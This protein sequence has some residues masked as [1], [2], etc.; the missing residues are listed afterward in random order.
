M[1]VNGSAKS[2]KLLIAGKPTDF[3]ER[4]LFGLLK[5]PEK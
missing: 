3:Q 5:L 4:K 2:H 1:D